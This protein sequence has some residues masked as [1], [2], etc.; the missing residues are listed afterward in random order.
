[1]N[2]NINN[3]VNAPPEHTFDSQSNYLMNQMYTSLEDSYFINSAAGPY[4]SLAT[5]YVMS[6]TNT[7]WQIPL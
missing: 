1:M 6:Q 3:N 2:R 5:R 4:N 7:V